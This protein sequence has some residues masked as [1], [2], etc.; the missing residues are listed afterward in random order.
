M[1]KRE[2]TCTVAGNVNWCIHYEKQYGDSSIKLKTE[3]QYNPAIPL[4]GLYTKKTKTLISKN[5]CIPMVTTALFTIVRI[6][7]HPKCLLIKE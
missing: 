5:T 3:L 2:P 7:K 1:E 6:H 4:L